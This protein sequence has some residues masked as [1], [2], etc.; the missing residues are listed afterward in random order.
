MDYPG[1][2]LCTHNETRYEQY[3][4][5]CHSEFVLFFKGA[6]LLYPVGATD[7]TLLRIV[8]TGSGVHPASYPVATGGLFP[9]STATEA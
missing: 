5:S 4:I 9:E 1:T 6:G 3:A 2:E 7:F 8:Q